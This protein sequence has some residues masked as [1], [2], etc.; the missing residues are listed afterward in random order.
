ME[1]IQSQE[2]WVLH[3]L[4]KILSESRQPTESKEHLIRKNRSFFEIDRLVCDKLCENA[5]H[6]ICKSTRE[7]CDSIPLIQKSSKSLQQKDV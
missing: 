3:R 1:E 4:E 6:N 2:Q 7:T 5:Q